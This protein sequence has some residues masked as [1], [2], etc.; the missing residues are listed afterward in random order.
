MDILYTK[1]YRQ[2]EKTILL[3]PNVEQNLVLRFK[4]L[5]N[6]G[7]QPNK[8]EMEK[9]F[10]IRNFYKFTLVN[11]VLQTN[12]NNEYRKQRLSYMCESQNLTNQGTPKISNMHI[13]KE[14]TTGT[15]Y[16]NE[17]NDSSASDTTVG[18]SYQVDESF[19]GPLLRE[20]KSKLCTPVTV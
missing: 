20:P 7:T 3:C 19:R 18:L 11:I 4:V 17:L 8:S 14:R 1:K 16:D 15:F 2:G 5:K 13:G 10:I 12:R 6:P 9:V